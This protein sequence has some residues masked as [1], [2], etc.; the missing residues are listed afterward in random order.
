M[1]EDSAVNM[2][3]TKLTCTLNGSVPGKVKTSEQGNQSHF[4]E[5]SL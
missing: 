5:E 1:V 4:E 2:Q 3:E